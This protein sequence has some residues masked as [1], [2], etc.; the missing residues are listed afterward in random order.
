MGVLPKLY[1]IV[2]KDKLEE[3]SIKR[4]LRAPT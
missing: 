4:A 3:V 1:G 2:M